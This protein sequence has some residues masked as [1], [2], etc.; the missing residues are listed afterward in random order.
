VRENARYDDHDE[1]GRRA[2]DR[3][4]QVTLRAAEGDDD[5]DDLE[6]LEEDALE[7]DRE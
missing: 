3:Q 2:C 6:A 1:G 7:G 4:T 5:E